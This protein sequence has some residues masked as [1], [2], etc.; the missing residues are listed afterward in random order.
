MARS[1]QTKVEILGQLTDLFKGS[2]SVVFADYQGLKVAKADELRKKMR[3]EGLTYMVAKKTVIN[4]AAKQAGLDLNARSLPGMI[5]VA[6]STSDEVAPAK[7]LG[8]MTKDTTIKLVGGI[9]GG[10][11][12]DG[13]YVTALSKLPSRQQLYGMFVSTIN[14]P[15]SGFVRA[16]D[17]I[18]KQKEAAA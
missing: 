12:V 1:K 6:F 9:F 16:L 2:T 18:R 5:G 13:A 15:V 3:G 10:K 17:A 4:L 7:V 14:G 8:D 11:A